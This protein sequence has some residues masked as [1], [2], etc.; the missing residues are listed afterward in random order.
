M[1]VLD[2]LSCRAVPWM[3]NSG[4]KKEMQQSSASKIAVFSIGKNSTKE[5][6]ILGQRSLQVL[7][8]GPLLRK[9]IKTAF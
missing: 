9:P 2:H 7:L 4:G 3:Q 5:D 8:F 1:K 6:E